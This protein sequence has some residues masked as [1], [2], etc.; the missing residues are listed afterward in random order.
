MSAV[1]RTNQEH[2]HRLPGSLR[3]LAL[4]SDAGFKRQFV[5]YRG[6]FRASFFRRRRK[7]YGSL[8]HEV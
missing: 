7:S 8:S 2:H 1:L 3:A 6:P 5:Q 4:L